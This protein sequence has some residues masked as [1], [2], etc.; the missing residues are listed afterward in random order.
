MDIDH[1][2]AFCLLADHKNYRIAAEHLHITQ[3]ALTK[4]NTTP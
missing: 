2:H 4:K 1:L 3:S